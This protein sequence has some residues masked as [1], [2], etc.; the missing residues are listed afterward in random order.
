MSSTLFTSSLAIIPQTG[1]SLQHIRYF[2]LCLDEIGAFSL[3]LLITLPTLVISLGTKL[4]S[5]IITVQVV[6]LHNKFVIPYTESR[7]VQKTRSEHCWRCAITS[8]Q[9]QPT[10]YPQ[11][12]LIFP[13]SASHIMA[14]G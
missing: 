7:V 3:A 8:S 6:E 12:R 5:L 2:L 10:L 14:T 13:H 9:Y 4:L 11:V 1:D